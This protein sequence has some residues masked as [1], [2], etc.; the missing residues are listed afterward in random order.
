MNDELKSENFT[1]ENEG[2]VEKGFINFKLVTT[3]IQHKCIGQRKK[4]NYR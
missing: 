1:D 4:K 3:A 2:V